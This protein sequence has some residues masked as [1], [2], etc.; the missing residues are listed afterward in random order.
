MATQAI[1]DF[2]F[3]NCDGDGVDYVIA[4]PD[5]FT[6]DRRDFRGLTGIALASDGIWDVLSNSAVFNILA[7]AGLHRIDPT[8]ANAPSRRTSAGSSGARSGSSREQVEEQLRGFARQVVDAAVAN[9]S[10]DDCTFIA[11]AIVADGS[12]DDECEP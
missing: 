3:K 4:T 8:L 1:G 7:G 9:R 12:S 6:I 10:R 11:A 2:E 5:V